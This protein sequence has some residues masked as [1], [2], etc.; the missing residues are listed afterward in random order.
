M[1][2]QLEQ[3]IH[4]AIT[5]D[6]DNWHFLKEY[7]Y[8]NKRILVLERKGEKSK[9]SKF[10]IHIMYPQGLV[11]YYKMILNNEKTRTLDIEKV[12]F[13]KE[14]VILKKGCFMKTLIYPATVKLIINL[15]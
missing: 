13:L 12:G 15:K 6:K 11:K 14:F 2:E 8:E 3:L 7:I 1:P 10:E 4:S 5:Q 9:S